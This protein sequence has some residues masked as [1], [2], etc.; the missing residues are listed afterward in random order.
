MIQISF[1]S[2]DHLLLLIIEK[3]KVGR[4]SKRYNKM[5]RMDF[6]NDNLYLGIAK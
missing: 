4:V 6:R 2:E 5:V 1:K 3:I